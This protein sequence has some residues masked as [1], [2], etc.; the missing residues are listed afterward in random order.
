MI[1]RGNIG[2]AYTYNEPLIG[3]EFVRDCAGFVREA[4]LCNVLVTNGYIN[5]AVWDI[6]SARCNCRT[7]G[8][9]ACNTPSRFPKRRNQ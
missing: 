2:V 5:L 3:Y 7:L 6:P 1:P 8:W 9:W 4:E